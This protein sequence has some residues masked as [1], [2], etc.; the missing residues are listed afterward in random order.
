M[1]D[2]H[3]LYV[4][5]LTPPRVLVPTMLRRPFIS[6][7]EP[8]EADREPAI[9]TYVEDV[10]DTV[11]PEMVI[12]AFVSSTAVIV[13]AAATESASDVEPRSMTV[14]TPSQPA[15]IAFGPSVV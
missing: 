7:D 12:V 5:G 3:T 9:D 2:C 14:P 11:A 15:R 1:S 13:R 8:S 10:V 6:Y 4:D